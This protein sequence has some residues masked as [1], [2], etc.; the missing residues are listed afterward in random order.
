MRIF[1]NL[2][3]K[4]K[5]IGIILS[6][7][8]FAI[9]LGFT[10]II[11]KD[12]MYFKKNMVDD[13]TLTARLIGDYCVTPLA[14]NDNAGAEEVL[15]KLKSIPSIVNG[16]IY[17]DEGNI[18]AV[19]N[20][21]VETSVSPLPLEKETST[22]F[23]WK[24][25][26]LFQPILYE[27]QKYGTIYLRVS[28]DLLVEKIKRYLLTMVILMIALIVI[29]F[30]ISNK[31]QDIISNPILKLAD[32]TKVI[33]E[34]GDYSIRV[35]KR[36]DFRKGNDEISILFNGFDNM[37]NQIHVREMERDRAE[38]KLNEHRE[39]LEELVKERTRELEK[40]TSEVEQANI[41][42][43]E[44]DRMKSMFIATMSHELRTPL[45]SIIGFT[46]IIIQGIAGEINDE[47][48]KQLTMVKNSANHLLAL[49]NDVIDVSKIEADKIDILIEE[50]DLSAILQALK[51]SF[52]VAIDKK[53][54]KMPLI[55]PE[56]III[57]SDERR[58]KQIIMNLVSNAVK[59][60][61]TGEIEIKASKS[62]EMIEISVRDTGLGMRKEDID[63]LFKAF[64]RIFNEGKIVEGTGLGLYLSKKLANLL[65]GD[66][67]VESEYGK[68]SI[69]ILELPLV[70]KERQI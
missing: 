11:I 39:H 55:M 43:K 38:E 7:S 19:F 63:R 23:E 66:M 15:G 16:I 5:L 51:D 40:Q 44:L 45:N 36:E 30:F 53:G 25:L 4:Y 6:V 26:H 41:K 57:K 34:D 13:T 48:K 21:S 64:S 17:D 68:G 28:T 52:T 24:Y 58:V 54:L 8:M 29:S 50:F 67:S 42:L 46:G 10:V 33:S 60:T 47:Q 49:I 3:I 12:I 65:G 18:F 70:H 56:K 32:V 2:S 22:V 61:D 14:F 1:R 31:L 37:L 9:V 69:F 59:F 62:D 20:K 27:N 35:E